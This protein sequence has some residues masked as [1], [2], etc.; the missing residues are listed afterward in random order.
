RTAF[1]ASDALE[2]AL[3]RLTTVE[4]PESVHVQLDTVPDALT[5]RWL[6]AL[7][8]A[9]IGVSWS[10][11]GGGAL[12][13]E[14]FRSPDPAGGIVLFAAAPRPASILSDGLGPIDTISVV[15][16]PAVVRLAS[17]EGD[18]TLR[19]GAQPARAGIAPTAA[20]RRVFVVGAA[21]W[22]AKFAI[23]A[24]EES[25][26]AVDARLFVR[27]DMDVVQGGAR[28]RLDTSRYAAVV[29][30][31]SAAAETTPVAEFVR[32]GGGVVLAGDAN[33]ARRIAAIVGWRGGTRESAPL[34]TLPGD[35]AWRG[36]SR[37]VLDSIPERRAVALEERGGRAVVVARRHYA[38]RVMGVGYDQTWRWRM[39]GGDNSAA[40]HRAWWSR[41]VAS[42]AARGEPEAEMTT[43]ARTGS[44]PLASLHDVLG[45][46]SE[47]RRSLAA[48]F[49]AGLL[50]SILGALCLAALLT[51][52]LLR[53]ARGAR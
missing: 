29:L 42:V 48:G 30:V 21:G 32:A 22:E 2:G 50:S 51:E 39:A 27:P 6:A 12:A 49:P 24:L 17:V 11:A 3:A 14:T 8:G 31:D 25:G 40:E 19:S 45:S 33:R 5:A 46:P 44:A 34:G 16:A 18:V 23:A 36:L 53:R 26:W 15:R 35:T 10:G 7:R 37:L 1:I 43:S 28:V 41:A 4:R 9:G 38:G 47:Q 20:P 52:W 13:L